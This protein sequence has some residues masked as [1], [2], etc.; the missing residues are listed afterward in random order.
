[1]VWQ[2]ILCLVIGYVFGLLQSGYIIG[3]INHIDIREYGS[4]NSGTTNT[5]RTLGKKWGI[6]TFLGDGLKPIF[7]IIVVAL[8]FSKSCE[9]HMF[10]ISIYAG[11]GAI[12][13]H[14]FPFYM[15]FKGGKGIATTGGMILAL[16][17]F[18]WRF[19]VCA[20]AT[21]F[22]CLVLTKYVSLS[23][24]LLTVGF[25]LEIVVWG[26]L[27]LVNGLAK[28]DRIETYIVVFVITVLSIIRHKE[29]IKRLLNGTERRV[30]DKKE[31]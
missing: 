24:M 27:G 12:L 29:N 4:G 1:M 30:G 26:Q 23:S 9:G 31:A 18:D 28:E 11:L 15:H 20:L 3:K 8:L 5:I 10:L 17:Y 14:N 6:L 7:A 2:K 19:V 25:F 21:F 22:L 16:A 13:G